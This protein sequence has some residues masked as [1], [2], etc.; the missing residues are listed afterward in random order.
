MPAVRR[1]TPGPRSNSKGA[2]NLDS[3]QY[4]SQVQLGLVRVERHEFTLAA[5]DFS[6][7]I[8]LDPDL[9]WGYFHRAYA[10]EQCGEKTDGASTTT[11]RG[12]SK[13]D[14]RLRVERTITGPPSSGN[15]DSPRKSWPTWTSAADLGRDE[16]TVHA[17]RAMALEA[18]KRYPESEDAIALALAKASD[19]PS[20]PGEE[21]PAVRI[22]WTYAFAISGRLPPVPRQ[23]FA[24][25]L[26]RNPQQP[27]ARCT[28]WLQ[29]GDGGRQRG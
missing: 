5:A 28:A 7:C 19:L 21:A 17:G 4:W 13:R 3:H 1:A 9:A 11:T 25:V 23:L 20:R 10:L 22:R 26:D 16:P 24:E 18:L 6:V 27:L 8:G 12:D 29:A 14:P 2:L 15:W